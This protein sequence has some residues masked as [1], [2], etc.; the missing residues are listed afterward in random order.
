MN[1]E[2]PP[3]RRL[4]LK[5]R[6]VDPVDKLSRPGDG[7]AISVRLIHLENRQA[8]ERAAGKWLGDPQPL[9]ESPEPVG[10][11]FKPKEITP[12]DPPSPAG[13]ASAIS[14]AGM[15]RANRSAAADSGPELIA[16]PRR[17]KSRRHRD[18]ILLVSCAFLSVGALA[19]VFR[20]D[21]QMVGLALLGIVFLTVIL[22][23]IMYGVMDRY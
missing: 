8:A 17:R 11:P 23:W 2:K 4:V 18:F 22:A 10:S 20:H 6:D 5:P 15:L 9:A 21:L 14:V 1:D 13:D 19:A 7:T 12:I 16:M 3:I